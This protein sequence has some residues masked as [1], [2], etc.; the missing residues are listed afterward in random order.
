MTS[1]EASEMNPHATGANEKAPWASIVSGVSMFTAGVGIWLR[2]EW[3][4]PLVGAVVI[5]EGAQFA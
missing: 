3:F 4:V 5:V 2:L 1:L